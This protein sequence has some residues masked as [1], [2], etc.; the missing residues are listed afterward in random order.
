L[1]AGV[2]WLEE[3]KRALQHVRG[4]DATEIEVSRPGLRL[5]VRRT[6]G[7]GRAAD[8]AIGREVA[9]SPGTT[10]VAP[11]TGIFYRASSPV[12]QPYVVEGDA[13]QP[14]TVVGLIEAMKIFNEVLAERRGRVREILVQAGELV[15]AGDR[16][17]MIDE[18]ADVTT[19]PGSL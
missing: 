1:V 7:M 8:V 16:L 9:P 2:A 3:V 13:V 17:M 10:I 6:P 14:E 11:L 4:S 12:T 19:G 5:R 18:A 15:Q